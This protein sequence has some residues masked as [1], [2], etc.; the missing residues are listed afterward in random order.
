[1]SESIVTREPSEP[2]ESKLLVAM[3]STDR[4]MLIG[5]SLTKPDFFTLDNEHQDKSIPLESRVGG[6]MRSH[7]GVIVMS[8]H[9]L[10][11]PKDA[12]EITGY[13]VYLRS[14]VDFQKSNEQGHFTP[15]DVRD[16]RHDLL[17]AAHDI[18]NTPEEVRRMSRIKAE[19]F[20]QVINLFDGKGIDGARRRA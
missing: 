20:Q 1:M 14:V 11:T 13:A 6:M 12:P 16:A 15:K 10:R 17:L 3:R 9:L 8:D 5:P 4:R 2:R 7:E 18:D 19:L